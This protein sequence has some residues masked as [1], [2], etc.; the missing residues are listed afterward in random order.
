[1][2][3]AASN[4]SELLDRAA[5]RRFQLRLALPTPTQTQLGR[6]FAAFAKRM[7][8]PLGFTPQTVAKSLGEISYAEAEEFCNGVHRRLALSL[9]EGSVKSIIAEQLKLWKARA[10]QPEAS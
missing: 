2:V 10:C 9:G 1:V 6:Y 4:P 3:I 7:E 5:W 8:E